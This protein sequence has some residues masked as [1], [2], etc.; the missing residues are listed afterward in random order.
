[1]DS[2]ETPTT[3]PQNLWRLIESAAEKGKCIASDCDPQETLSTLE[4]ISWWWRYMEEP[5]EYDS[6]A[7]TIHGKVLRDA[8][9]L[10]VQIIEN[11]KLMMHTCQEYPAFIYEMSVRI[12]K[13]ALVP[14]PWVSLDSSI[15]LPLIDAFERPR[16]IRPVVASEES[17][18][19]GNWTN[20]CPWCFSLSA[21]DSEIIGAFSDFIRSQRQE[22][23]I[24]NPKPNVGKR[25]RGFSWRPIEILDQK[26]IGLVLNGSDRSHLSKA[27]REVRAALG[28]P[29]RQS[30]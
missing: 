29:N 16:V 28:I 11:L 25:N 12:V 7:L 19:G 22:K 26:R 1:M 21:T 9:A 3:A 30:E 17:A 13:P 14:I 27:K 24:P 10:D 18:V 8:F 6:F 4:R 2:S 5:V 15:K 23:G 20:V